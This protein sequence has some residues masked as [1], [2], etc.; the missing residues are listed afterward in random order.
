MR[1][2]IDPLMKSL[3]ASWIPQTAEEVNLVVGLH[4]GRHLAGR[5]S[6]GS[7]GYQETCQF[8]VYERSTGALIIEGMGVG[9][10]PRPTK[11]GNGK[12]ETYGGSADADVVK[13]IK[14]ELEKLATAT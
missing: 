2:E 9:S 7:S 3:D 12:T 11:K 4:W 1:G 8:A 5:Y 6:D 14:D 10:L 13:L